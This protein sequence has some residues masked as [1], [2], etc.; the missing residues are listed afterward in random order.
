MVLGTPWT[1][2]T[3]ALRVLT[4]R[5]L[6]DLHLP[7]DQ[8]IYEPTGRNT[9]P[10]IALLCQI[11]Q[12]K[13]KG[14]EVVGVFPADHL[15]INEPR[16]YPAIEQACQWAQKDRIVTLGV[17]PTYAA[18]G[19]G[20]IETIPSRVT[21]PESALAVRQFCEK[22]DL[23]KAEKFLEL[24]NYYWNAGIFIFQVDTLADHFRRLAPSLWQKI[25]LVKEDLSN[26]P[27]IYENVQK[28][29]FDYAVME[30]LN[31]D[32]QIC[33]PVDLGWSDLGSWEEM[34]KAIPKGNVSGQVFSTDKKDGHFIMSSIPEKIYAL[35]DTK[36]L[37]IA[38]TVDALLIAPKGKSHKIQELL[39]KIDSKGLPQAH[40]HKCE[41][42]P[43][44]EFTVL[45]DRTHFKSKRIV[46]LPGAQLSYQSHGQRAEHWIV[47]AGQG[48]VVLND[49]VHKMGPS[50]HIFIP[51]GAKHRM[52]NTGLD[53]LEFIEVQTGSYFGEEDIIRY[54]D[55]YHRV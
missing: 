28:I 50:D 26:L 23:A 47:V 42:R 38:D 29:S 18:T 24:G 22:P 8:V 37:I 31:G 43:W 32:E 54:Q 25:S 36:E 3:S 7:V 27:E 16:F 39:K 33:I 30:K 11:F 52:R 1:I 15:V 34:A 20:Y 48:E 21:G 46:V 10:A 4:E 12:K 45:M 40:E 35:V 6:T 44:G 2:T 5:A 13:G 14:Q 17:L 9:A 55:D 53:V 49:E 19:Y 51:Q 41:V